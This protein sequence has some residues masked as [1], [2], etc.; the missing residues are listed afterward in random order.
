MTIR[1]AFAALFRR[2]SASAFPVRS[3]PFRLASAERSGPAL[4]TA[5]MPNADGLA[6]L[7]ARRLALLTEAARQKH[8][9]RSKQASSIEASL[10]IVTHQI[11]STRTR[12]HA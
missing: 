10:R 6:L 1:A 2:R 11:L 4:P 8:L 9:R 12:P 7:Q 5:T 3:Q